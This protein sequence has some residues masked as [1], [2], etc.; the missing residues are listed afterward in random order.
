MSGVKYYKNNQMVYE[1]INRPIYN[2]HN[3]NDKSRSS[4][5][6]IDKSRSSSTV[7]VSSMYYGV[8]IGVICIICWMLWA[9]FIYKYDLDRLGNLV[10]AKYLVFNQKNQEISLEYYY[11]YNNVRLDQNRQ[12][13]Y[14]DIERRHA[15]NQFITTRTPVSYALSNKETCPIYSPNC[16]AV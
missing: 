1:P 12:R 4:S 15:I 10:L 6:V 8:I 11:T 3:L 14:A 7:I 5:T 9:E 13:V 16:I 2:T